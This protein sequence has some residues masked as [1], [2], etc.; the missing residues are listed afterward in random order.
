L[1]VRRIERGEWAALRDVRLAAL[2]DAPWAF[3]SSLERES[4]FDEATW[5]ERAE[6]NAAGAWIVGF[7]AEAGGGVCGLAGG[8]VEG[9]E[10]E[11]GEGRCVELVG[12]WVS[13][14][15]RGRGLGRALVEAVCGWARSERGASAVRLWVAE[16]N[17][18]A[19]AMYRRCGFRETG[20][21]RAMARHPDRREVRMVRGLELSD[22]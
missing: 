7:F 1:V 22:G 15:A 14:E 18:G 16:G 11:G 8:I 6:S 4:A 17:D 12:M 20:E 9:E 3:G 19:A 13:P 5:R 21:A 2:G 10:E